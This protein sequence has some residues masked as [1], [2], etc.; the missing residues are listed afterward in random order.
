MFIETL[1]S[2][3]YIAA[4]V[5]GLYRHVAVKDGN[6]CE[7]IQ[8][9]LIFNKPVRLFET[10]TARVCRLHRSHFSAARAMANSRRIDA[11]GIFRKPWKIFGVRQID[12]RKVNTNLFP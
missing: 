2:S 9:M 3:I 11:R 10:V 5:D 6:V 7:W 1:F 8:K 4:L 12:L